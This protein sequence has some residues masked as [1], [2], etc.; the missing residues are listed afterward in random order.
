M[1]QFSSLEFSGS[2]PQISFNGN[3]PGVFELPTTENTSSAGYVWYS[4]PNIYYSAHVGVWHTSLSLPRCRRAGGAFGNGADDNIFAGGCLMGCD[5]RCNSST[6]EVW[7]GSSWAAG[8]IMTNEHGNGVAG[9]GTT[10]AGLI[11]GG[12]YNQSPVDYGGMKRQPATEE[13]NGSSWSSGG[14][15]ITA[16][17]FAKSVGTQD[18]A[19]YYGGNANGACGCVEEYNGSSWSTGTPPPIASSNTTYGFGAGT[20]DAIYTD[21]CNSTTNSTQKWNG[22]SWSTI[23]NPL[24]SSPYQDSSFGDST[25]LGIIYGRPGNTRSTERYDGNTWSTSTTSN[26]YSSING[27]GLF[28]AGPGSCGM[29]IGSTGNY[30][31][32]EQYNENVFIYSISGT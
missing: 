1:A 28:A 8:A 30:F 31:G 4:D 9:T 26:A 16:R 5:T 17:N 23:S 7:N 27:C 24:T 22:S 10:S 32:A 2:N 19:F 11:V 25:N 29:A 13:Y 12:C 6:T 15:T 21:C 3:P 14:N 18:A 20:N